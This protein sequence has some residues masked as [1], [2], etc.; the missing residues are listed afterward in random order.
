MFRLVP[1]ACVLALAALTAGCQRASSGAG[2]AM[3]SAAPAPTAS[4]CA[5]ALA[6]FQRVI[7]S[8]KLTGNLNESVYG[9]MNSDLAP[10]KS[11]C[12]SGRDA[13]AMRSLSG[14]R[15]KYG[16]PEQRG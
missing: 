13:D 3:A 1:I 9:R 11:A 16:Y 4:G 7:N 8:D 6:N 15:A 5:G 2:P 14:V 10:A 12:A